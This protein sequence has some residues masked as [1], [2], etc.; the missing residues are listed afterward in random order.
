MATTTARLRNP[1]KLCLLLIRAAAPAERRHHDSAANDS[2]TCRY[3]TQCTRPGVPSRCL[4]T[5]PLPAM[6][7][8]LARLL[9]QG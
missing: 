7:L 2:A 3:L 8:L 5:P 6:I 4:P 9:A 1:A